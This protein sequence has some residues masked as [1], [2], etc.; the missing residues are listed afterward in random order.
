[1]MMMMTM[2]VATVT[3]EDRSQILRWTSFDFCCMTVAFFSV[4]G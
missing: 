4:L 1:M 3:R 2:K